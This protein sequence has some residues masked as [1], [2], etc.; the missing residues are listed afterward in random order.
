[1]SDILYWLLAWFLVSVPVSLV[2]AQLL[3]AASEQLQ[4]EETE[5]RLQIR[6][7]GRRPFRLEEAPSRPRRRSPPLGASPAASR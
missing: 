3:K 6:G 1:M 2:L 4:P 5:R 7:S